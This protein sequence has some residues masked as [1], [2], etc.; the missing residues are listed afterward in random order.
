[1][2][3]KQHFVLVK[4]S[5]CF[6]KNATKYYYYYCFLICLLTYLLK[7]QTLSKKTWLVRVINNNR[8]N[9]NVGI[10]S[11]GWRSCRIHWHDGCGHVHNDRI[12]RVGT[13]VVWALVFEFSPLSLEHHVPGGAVTVICWPEGVLIRNWPP[14][15]TPAGM[16]TFICCCCGICCGICCCPHPISCA[17]FRK[18]PLLKALASSAGALPVG[19]GTFTTNC[20]PGLTPTGTVVCN[21][22]PEGVV[23][24]IWLPG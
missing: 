1:M 13:C 22:C 2:T 16:T 6:F 8:G 21:L 24:A 4:I 10:I 5:L 20:I 18:S 15:T 12:A 7:T 19:G 14:A 23:I 3:K 17:S 9:S 11:L